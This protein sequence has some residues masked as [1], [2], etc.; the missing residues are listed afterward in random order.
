MWL[1]ECQIL[2]ILAM[3]KCLQNLLRD[4]SLSVIFII[5]K[6]PFYVVL[7]MLKMSKDNF[8]RDTQYLPFSSM[9]MHE[10]CEF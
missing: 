7:I 10:I 2:T 8:F 1:F 4:S 6:F 5:K 9:K 3:T